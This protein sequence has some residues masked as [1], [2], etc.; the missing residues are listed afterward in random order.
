MTEENY[1]ALIERLTM[2]NTDAEKGFKLASE[3]A[4]DEELQVWFEYRSKERKSMAEE[5]RLSME[6]FAQTTERETTIPGTIHRA[7]IKLQQFLS[8]DE[9][10][11]ELLITECKLGET[12]LL[13]LYKRAIFKSPYI[14]KIQGVLEQHKQYVERSLAYLEHAIEKHQV[15]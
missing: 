9:K 4:E 3:Q 7:Y 8:S 12:E 10:S 5:L 11:T 13:N 15:T 6:S 2:L 1:R 14:V